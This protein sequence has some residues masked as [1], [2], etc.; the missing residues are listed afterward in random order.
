[1]ESTLQN[2]D[3]SQ[4]Q[5]GMSQQAQMFQYAQQA[6]Q[7]SNFMSG[8][9][10]YMVN[11]HM[12]G[13]FA[14]NTNSA[15]HNN[16]Q[17]IQDGSNRSQNQGA[18]NGKTNGNQDSNMQAFIFSQNGGVPSSIPV[19]SSIQAQ[20]KQSNSLGGQ[21]MT[22]QPM[23]MNMAQHNAER[24]PVFPPQRFGIQM[25][26]FPNDKQRNSVIQ[27][28]TADGKEN[29]NSNL[30]NN[31]SNTLKSSIHDDN[32]K[33][34]GGKKS[35]NNNDTTTNNRINNNN[36]NDTSMNNSN[37]DSAGG[38]TKQ[39]PYFL[40]NG[41][42]ANRNSIPTPFPTMPPGPQ[43]KTSNSPGGNT[44]PQFDT[45]KVPAGLFAYPVRKYLASMAALKFH[46]LINTINMSAGRITEALYWKTFINDMF[47]PDAV[48]RYAK[49]SS[50]DFRQF[51]FLIPLI[52]VIFVTLGKLG[53]IRIEMV[54]QQLKTEV[55]SNGT[56]FFDCPKCTFTYHY[57][58]GSYITHFVQ[59]KG[60]FN[61]N[62][63]IEWGDLCM[64]SFVP[65]IE[66]NALER[67]VS[68]RAASYE[69][70]QKLSNPEGDAKGKSNIKI[71]SDNKRTISGNG[72][73]EPES[74]P[75][76]ATGYN[77]DKKTNTIIP[78]NFDAI[79][80]LRSYF[81]VFRN[82][83][84]FGSQE[85]LMRVMQVSTVMSE[86]KNLKV[87]QKLNN[88]QSPLDALVSYVNAHRN[89]LNQ[90]PSG[91]KNDVPKHKGQHNWNGDHVREKMTP[92]MDRNSDSFNAQNAAIF[93]TQAMP[94]SSPYSQPNEKRPPM[95]RRRTSGVSPLSTRDISTPTDL[96][97]SVEASKKKHKY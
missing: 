80:Q 7:M 14:G 89:E 69:I 4:T 83:S 2:E 21:N 78:S 36:N 30:I 48:L 60:L 97:E 13:G 6:Q 53:V 52:P 90:Q 50:T 62:F 27:S 16:N 87:H 47:T 86:L 74:D 8:V 92:N 25:P 37:P 79:T 12:N 22:G 24:M 46:E 45:S 76:T 85:G 70:F 75:T 32:E 28:P 35:I 31:K 54:I 73:N 88:I 1:M 9:D 15:G 33:L 72:S 82:V 11:A 56:V 84:V 63:K 51:D 66:W 5:P 96:N 91:F 43:I 57:P 18:N 41:L 67:L 34:S 65:G 95:K 49:T 64:H 40:R 77:D 44:N 3:P 10:P 23:Q 38:A 26:T 93:R 20:L 81:S 42:S 58:D 29:S 39:F 94:V 68:D 59:L 71:E 19:D 61:S 17:F 55:L